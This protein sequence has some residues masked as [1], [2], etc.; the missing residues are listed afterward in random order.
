MRPP[1]VTTTTLT[2]HTSLRVWDIGEGG[3]LLESRESLPV[4]TVGMLSIELDGETRREWFRI[5]RVHADEGRR[6]TCLLA[7]EFLPLTAAGGESVRGT[8]RQWRSVTNSPRQVFERSGGMR[9]AWR[10]MAGASG[11]S[12]GYPGKFGGSDA[13]GVAAS[14]A[15]PEE[16]HDTT[17]TSFVESSA[18]TKLASRLL[19][20]STHARSRRARG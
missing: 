20:W 3:C 17:A 10:G 14:M 5:C 4:G 1:N 6:G 8:L 2:K 19:N 18:T 11:R 7:A 15:E 9:G 16:S 12:S 13:S